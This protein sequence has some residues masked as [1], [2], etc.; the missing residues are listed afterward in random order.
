M[1]HETFLALH[2]YSPR[3]CPFTFLEA[4]EAHVLFFYLYIYSFIYLAKLDML[5]KQLSN[6][7][8]NHCMKSN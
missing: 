1:I 4:S 7:K 8:K 2:E 6:I 5:D 3:C